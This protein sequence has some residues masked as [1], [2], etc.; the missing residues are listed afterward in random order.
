MGYPGVRRTLW[1]VLPVL[2]VAGLMLVPAAGGAGAQRS[3]S[4][5]SNPCFGPMAADLRCPDLVMRRPFGLRAERRGRRTVLRAGNSIDSVG[6][7]PAELRGRRAGRRFMNAVQSI[8]TRGGRRL[9]Y[10]TGARLQ[11]KLAHASRSYW[12]FYRAASFSLWRIDSA[13]RPTRRVR[14]GPKVAYCLRDLRRTRNFA[15]SRRRARYPACN[16]NPRQRRV[17]LGT[18]PGWSDVYPPSYPEQWIDVTG[19]RGCFAYRHTADP[20]NW[21]YESN[22]G[23]NR[24]T[25]IVRLPYRKRG[26]RRCPG[27]DSG[28]APP[29]VDD[30]Y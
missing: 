17:V 3:A 1:P 26:A 25:V 21:I 18:S 7:G 29:P 14:T 24:S 19:L 28:S 2:A 20:R 27:Q 12:K 22:E 16:T 8:Y 30:A 23:N 5:D 13:G 10:R 6:S 4:R 11:F 9:T 15:R